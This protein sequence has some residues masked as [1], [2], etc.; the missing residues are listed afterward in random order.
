MKTQLAII[1]SRT[2]L[3]KKQ[4]KNIRKAAK[5]RL[6]RKFRVLVLS[7]LDCRIVRLGD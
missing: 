4:S 6:G 7:A 5:K 3:T 1:E 2:A